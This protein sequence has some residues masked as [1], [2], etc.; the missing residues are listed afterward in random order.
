MFLI[1]LFCHAV[2]FPNCRGMVFHWRNFRCFVHWSD[3][4]VDAIRVEAKQKAFCDVVAIS[5]SLWCEAGLWPAYHRN[6]QITDPLIKRYTWYHPINAPLGQQFYCLE[7][8]LN[9]HFCENPKSHKHKNTSRWC[10]QM[11][12]SPWLKGPSYVLGTKPSE[13]TWHVY[14]SK[15]HPSTK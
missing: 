7:E 11:F 3:T 1:K 9:K 8:S 12:S 6:D 10:Q 5:N 2:N 13:N 15:I 4:H 14:G